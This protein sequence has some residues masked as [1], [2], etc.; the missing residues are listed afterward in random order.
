MHADELSVRHR[1]FVFTFATVAS[2]YVALQVQTGL[3]SDMWAFFIAMM[4][5]MPA[6]CLLKSTLRKFSEWSQKTFPF[7]H[8]RLYI[9]VE[10]ILLLLAISGLIV[11]FGNGALMPFNALAFAMYSLA[12]QMGAE[13]VSLI[14]KYCCCRICCPCCVPLASDMRLHLIDEEAA[15]GAAGLAAP[16]VACGASV[17][18]V[19]AVPEEG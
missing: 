9:R 15:T 19:A 5:V 2:V 4:V 11:F 13:F 1:L 10:E 16:P 3:H 14:Y 6:T 12:A 7:V 17:Q 8:T 18:P